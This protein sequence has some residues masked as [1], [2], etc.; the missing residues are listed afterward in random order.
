M[1][2]SQM[3]THEAARVPA[4]SRLAGGAVPAGA[5]PGVAVHAWLERGV[6]V[7]IHLSASVKYVQTTPIRRPIVA[8][9]GQR[10]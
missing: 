8:A 10:R 4:V 1:Y 5:V 7:P 3:L 6:F 9:A 2:D